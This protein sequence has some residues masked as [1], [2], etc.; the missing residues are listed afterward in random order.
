MN[1][2]VVP[3]SRR[4]FLKRVGL[5]ASVLA[6]GGYEL[7][8]PRRALA[9]T[10]RPISDFVDAQGTTTTFVPPVPDYIG[11][12]DPQISV[13]ASFDYAGLAN[14]WIE[15]ESAGAVSFGT[16]TTGSVIDRPLRDGRSHVS[17]ELHTS[18]ALTYVLDGCVD[19]ATDPLL[20]GARAHEVFYDGATPV[21]GDGK[22]AIDFINTAPGI[23]L[24]D[25]L[26]ALLFGPPID[27]FELLV[28]TMQASA[29]GTLLTDGSPGR[30][31]IIQTG[32]F[33]TSFMGATGDAFPA[34]NI[35]LRRVGN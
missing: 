22:F 29:R 6:A 27:G 1:S 13:C 14:K 16:T 35:Y 4:E 32:L 23:P 26:I 8:R 30:V 21:L 19:F 7:L 2:S 25:L 33:M 11:W 12:S 18:N 9:A 3:S 20:M 5:P 10:K 15:T 28:L 24:P 31:H 34:E 17:V